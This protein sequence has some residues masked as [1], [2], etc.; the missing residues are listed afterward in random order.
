[1]MQQMQAG[2]APMQMPNMVNPQ[3]RQMTPMATGMMMTSAR[4]KT[5]PDQSQSGFGFM[6][7]GG[8]SGMSNTGNGA[9]GGLSQQHDAF[10]FVKDDM[11]SK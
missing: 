9:T 7:G 4:G 5:I 3:Q 1:M 2:N 10:S 6:G 8:A 11:R